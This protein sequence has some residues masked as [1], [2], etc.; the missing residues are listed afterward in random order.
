[1]PDMISSEVALVGSL[2]EKSATIIQRIQSA[3]VASDEIIRLVVL[4]LL[5]QGHVLVD[6]F[7]G[8]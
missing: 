6:D 4:G 1:M 7:P 3:V 5:C 8:V 2:P